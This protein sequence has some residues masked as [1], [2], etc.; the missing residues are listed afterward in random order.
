MQHPGM[1]L[2]GPFVLAV[3]LLPALALGAAAAPFPS[4]PGAAAGP[5]QAAPVTPGQ[6]AELLDVLNDPH[7]RA[8]FAATL[9]AM[10]RALPA[11]APA[12]AGPV[13][14]RP[15]SLGAAL[16]TQGSRWFTALSKQMVLLGRAIG[17]FPLLGAWVRDV[18]HDPE[19][20]G[21][22]LDASWTL[23]VV[24]AGS[25]ALEVA[26]RLALRRP[27]AALEAWTPEGSGEPDEVAEGDAPGADATPCGPASPA[28]ERA[29]PEGAALDQTALDQTAL[30][31]AVLDQA[32]LDQAVL[33]QAVLDQTALDQ[34]ALDR[35]VL[36][37]AGPVPDPPVPGL[38]GQA[39]R[40]QGGRDQGGRD[41]G[42]RDQ[43]GRDAAPAV[44]AADAAADAADDA[45]ALRAEQRQSERQQRRHRTLRALRRLPFALLRLVLELIPVGVFLLAANLLLG[46]GLG[47]EPLTNDVVSLTVQAW[48][49]VRVTLCVL[50][51]LV[52]PGQPRLR[53][54]H[55]SDGSAAYTL[56]W[57]RRLVVLF[58][59]GNAELNVGLLFGLYR[60]A[61]DGLLKLVGL[62]LHL[63]LVVMVL[64]CRGAVA[65]RLRAGKRRTGVFARLLNRM[66]AVWHW[67]AI[68]YIMALWVV[69][70]A[71]LRNGYSRL[72]HFFFVTA[73]V[74]V[75]ARLA[76]ILVLGGLDRAVRVS[77]E[78]AQRFPGLETRAGHY[79]PVV[80]AALSAL[81]M[82]LTAVALLE[83]WGVDSL[84]WLTGSQLGPRVVS[85]AITILVSGALAIGVWEGVNTAADR[86]LA[87]LG[88]DAQLVRAARLRTLLPILRTALFIGLAVVLGL[89][90]LSQIGVNIAPLLAGAGIVGVAI[91][92][93]SQKLVQDF[94]TGIFLLLENAMQV[95]D[96][97]TVAG[98]S[99]VVET[100]SI[101]TI[102]LRAGDGSIHIIPF[103]SVT[104]VNN[105][106][107]DFANADV[108][109]GVA[110]RED[111]DRVGAVLGDIVA[112]MR[113][114][115]GFSALI[116]GELSLW[117][118]DAL[119][120]FAVTIKGQIR[121]TSGGR[122][123]VQREFNR[124]VKKRFEAEGIDIPFPVRTLL[125]PDL[126]GGLVEGGPV[127]GPG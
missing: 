100:L 67:I 114:D 7:K 38:S 87:R 44:A 27:I 98:L 112:G 53:L 45:A 34:T 24:M 127:A 85:A 93:G 110:Y 62:V 101:R 123:P 56:A 121:T 120:D 111:T 82:T 52:S 64:Q 29:R 86:Q 26:A 104:T 41:Q 32:V 126:R 103:S 89:T 50:R 51:A 20:R 58:V 73:A 17:D 5:A 21:R 118:V 63:M 105:A 28:V 3:A 122:W 70:A 83:V 92:F 106:N 124:R 116:L 109:V 30:D 40:D 15:D 16:L 97:V 42:G 18:L 8:Q 33:D 91:G 19:A 10:A 31:R 113:A 12:S 72:L 36:R 76:G 74:S 48:V 6:A 79:Y 95:G 65:A 80:R 81:L 59:F 90:V 9:Q 14:L 69:W 22:V 11:T 66:A 99:G 71:A 39:G 47:A 84:G 13:P 49:V 43:G 54:L 94:I 88:R 35:A 75:T 1:R 57:A 117:G 25:I 68:F 4:L 55:V 96:T 119:G 78:L 46:V 115:P 125:M 107:R 102:R 60:D 23:A 77:P 37:Q 61:H 2:P 108:T